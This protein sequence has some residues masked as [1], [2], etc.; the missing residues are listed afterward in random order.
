MIRLK[1]LMVAV[2]PL[3]LPIFYTWVIHHYFHEVFGENN[4]TLGIYS[5]DIYIPLVIGAIFCLYHM[6]GNGVNVKLR[7]HILM[8]SIGLLFAVIW[9][10][11]NYL[12]L[13]LK[14]P[15]SFL[16][17]ALLTSCCALLM[18]AFFSLIKPSEILSYVNK[19]NTAAVYS[20]IALVSLLNYPMILKFLWRHASFLTAKSV[21]YL[22]KL[23]G[24]GLGL[25][26]TP[27]SFNLHGGG[28]GI[29][30]VMGCSGLEGIFFFVF[31][32]SLLQLIGKK[33]IDFRVMVAYLAGA[34]FLFLLNTVRISTFYFLGIQFEKMELGR[35]GKNWIEGAFHNHVGWILYLLGIIIFVRIYRKLE[36][37]GMGRELARTC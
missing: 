25:T 12:L 10:L 5:R 24:I 34:V 7:P 18:L 28:F 1:K 4:L 26:L 31:A 9:V 32:F 30:I 27:V 13:T 21:C 19:R 14:F 22:Y 17:I 33:G 37:K 6:V 3:G 16:V 35:T 11:K 23:F 2:S 20:L 29:R 36:A 15:H 8:L